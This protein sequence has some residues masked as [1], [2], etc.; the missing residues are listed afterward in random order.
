MS[1]V[2]KRLPEI[3]REDKTYAIALW[4]VNPEILCFV[5]YDHRKEK[6]TLK[7]AKSLPGRICY[8]INDFRHKSV[9]HCENR[10]YFGTATYTKDGKMKLIKTNKGILYNVA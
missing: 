3:T 1:V 10:V 7:Q 5:P 8:E 2:P 4:M 9:V 6:I